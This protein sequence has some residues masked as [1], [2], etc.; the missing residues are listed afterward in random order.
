MEKLNLIEQI[1]LL[2]NKYNS[3]KANST[4]NIPRM[5]NIQQNTFKHIRSCK[6]ECHI[7][8]IDPDLSN[9]FEK[10]TTTVLRRHTR[11]YKW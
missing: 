9:V 8:P 6:K 3:K 4:R 2:Q 10:E 1:E 5:Y 11:H 7:R